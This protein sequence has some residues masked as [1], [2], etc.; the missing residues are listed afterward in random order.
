[1]CNKL[2]VD[3]VKLLCCG[4]SICEPCEY[5]QSR[6]FSAEMVTDAAPGSHEIPET[7]AVCTHSPTSP[8]ECLPDKKLRNT[9]RAFVRT[10]EKKRS[11]P[12]EPVAATPVPEPTPTPAPAPSE[13]PVPTTEATNQ[14]NTAS[15]VD[16]EFADKAPFDDSEAAPTES[17]QIVGGI[18]ATRV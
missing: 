10:E 15:A 5:L 4:T 8:E 3:A 2:A 16:T 6:A 9:V 11:K 13:T 7:C 1:M 18:A 14:P 17:L 12:T